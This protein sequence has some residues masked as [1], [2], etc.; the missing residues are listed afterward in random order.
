LHDAAVFDPGIDATL[1]VDR[2]VFG[3]MTVAD[4]KLL[5]RREARV[6]FVLS[7]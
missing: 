1:G 3:L 4:G 2:D 6:A 5:N 7:G